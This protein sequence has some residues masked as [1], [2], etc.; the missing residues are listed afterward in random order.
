MAHRTNVTTYIYIPNQFIRLQL[1]NYT[2][3]QGI[4]LFDQN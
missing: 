2:V 4:K 1:T 3:N